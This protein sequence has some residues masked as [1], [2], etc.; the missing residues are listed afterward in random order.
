MT[1][2]GLGM[3]FCLR[4]A[5]R[6]IP[7]RLSF[8]LV[9]TQPKDIAGN[10]RGRGYDASDVE[11]GDTDAHQGL[12]SEYQQDSNDEYEEGDNQDDGFPRP[13]LRGVT[14]AGHNN[15]NNDDD[16]ASFDEEFGELQAAEDEWQKNNELRVT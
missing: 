15:D 11:Q 16:S 7:N 9:S 4:K 12:L 2:L 14:I 13:P 5:N 10:R 8:P 1:L 3:C 6:L